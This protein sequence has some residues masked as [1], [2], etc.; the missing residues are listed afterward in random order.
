MNPIPL[1]PEIAAVSRRV[2]WFEE[3]QKA[4]AIPERFVAY[5]MHEDMAVVRKYLSDDHLKVALFNAPAGIFDGH[6]W[7]YWNLKFGR[8][9]TPLMPERVIPD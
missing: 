1:T 4:I 6:S 5:A 8:Y 2:I 3:P 9:P 7:A